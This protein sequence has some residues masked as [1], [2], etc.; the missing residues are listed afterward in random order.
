M[1]RWPDVLIIGAY[2]AGLSGIGVYFSRRQTSTEQ[3]FVA[4]RSVPGWAMGMSLLATIITSITF[5]AYPG[6]AY[7][8]NWALIVPG[9]VFLALL[10]LIGRVIVPFFRHSVR[11]SAYEY[12]GKRFGPGIRLY[13]SLAFALGH[14]LKM[15]FVFYL[16]SLTVSG[17]TGWKVSHILITAGI[18]T[19]GYTLIGGVEAVIWS[20]VLQGFVLWTGICVCIGFLLFLPP[21]GPHAALS[22]AWHYHKF[23]LGSAQ[24]RLDEPSI[25]VLVIYG[26]FFYLQKYSADQT[27]V[28]R[29]LVARTD[30][31]ALRGITLG[32][33]LCIPVWSAFMLIGSLLWAFYRLTG[34]KLPVGITKPDQIF[35]HF[36][37]T[38]IPVGFAGLFLSALF[39]SAMSMLA[40]D[41]N[42][43]AVIGVEDYYMLLRPNSTDRAR[44]RAG[45]WIVAA[46]GLTAAGA[47]WIL[48]HS[49]GP[50]LSLYYT[51]TAIVAGGLAGLFLLAFLCTR[52][53]PRAAQA[54]VI[55][56]VIVTIWATLT[57]DG[58]KIVDFGRWNF[59]WHEYMIGAV[60]NVVLFII[61]FLF[62][63]IAPSPKIDDQGLTL[64]GW[65]QRRFVSE[66]SVAGEECGI[67]VTKSEEIA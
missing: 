18:V 60:S 13:S 63:V 43:L 62:S 3:Y 2:L 4:E 52:A 35:P 5:I 16:L 10:I 26:F 41:M 46:S 51:A 12:F 66:P 7:A 28:Q 65:L 67:Q 49:T 17:M 39:G 47:G 48:A 45:R 23:S 29:Y 25:A 20:D 9:L 50:A 56:S 38:H 6:S 30:R 31:S 57:A 24:L 22:L 53:G 33:V 37:V 21:G 58:G 32:A 55:A 34:E 27:V 14:F 64:W 1:V 11:M 44:L 40:S 59:G 19:I 54:G 36:L 8:G 42:C 15:G 61:G